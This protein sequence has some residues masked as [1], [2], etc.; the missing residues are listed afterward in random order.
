MKV[1]VVYRSKTGFTKKY[2]E[3]IAQDLGAE[4][5]PVERARGMSLDAY[6]TVVFGGSLHAVGI[7]GV[8]FVKNNPA[9]FSGKRLAV[10]A[11][12][13]SPVREETVA[14]VRGANFTPEQVARMGFFY[15]RGGFDM[16]KQGLIDRLLM[17]MLRSSLESKRR[18]NQTLSEDEKGM[19]AAYDAPLDFTDRAAIAPLVAYVRGASKETSGT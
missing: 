12:G 6:D 19:L 10:F 17:S 11:V 16:S 7:N 18:K 4:A 1:L 5:V 13:A 8:K 2:A 15:F 14:R 9:R 3:W